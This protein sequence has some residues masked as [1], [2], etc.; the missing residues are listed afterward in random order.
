VRWLTNSGT[1]RGASQ[2]GRWVPRK[3]LSPIMRPHPRRH[4]AHTGYLR[5]RLDRDEGPAAQLAHHRGQLRRDRGV[6]LGWHVVGD[7]GGV[8]RAGLECGHYAGSG[9]LGQLDLDQLP[10]LVDA[11]P[12]VRDGRGQCGVGQV[13]AGLAAAAPQ[14]PF[15]YPTALSGDGLAGQPHDGDGVMV[16][17]P[18]K[19]RR[20]G[21]EF[22]PGQ[23]QPRPSG[24]HPGLPQQ[25][26]PLC[27]AGPLPA[28]QLL[29]HRPAAELPAGLRASRGQAGQQQPGHLG[30][31]RVLLADKPQRGQVAGGWRRAG[32]PAA[33]A[34]LGAGAASHRWPPGRTTG[35][36]R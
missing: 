30:A 36:V 12:A 20:P 16:G 24:Q 11:L 10:R 29:A 26:A 8:R 4:V 28:A 35:R 22:H 13:P 14:R 25:P 6:H 7:T 1:S 3:K 15:A 33:G 17:Q 2:P 18:V 19:R 23:A 31:D 27:P 32:V 5:Q 34:T 9:L 21:V